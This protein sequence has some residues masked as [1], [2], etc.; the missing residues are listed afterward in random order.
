M[1]HGDRSASQ[2]EDQLSARGVSE[3]ERVEAIATLARTGLLDDRRFAETRAERLAD[4]GAGNAFIR[5]DLARAGV[6][7]ELVDH[8]VSALESERER[9]ERIVAR[10]G[11]GPKTARYLAG[12]GFSEDVIYAAVARAPDDT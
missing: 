7:A 2:I 6:D 3:D 8:A 1:R 10:R 12:K 11:P 9:A 5:H 4:R